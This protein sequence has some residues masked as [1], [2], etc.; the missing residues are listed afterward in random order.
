[1]MLEDLYRLLRSS[2]VQAQG[3][4]DTM[5]QPVVVLDQGFCVATAN[6]AFIRTF[7][8]ERDDILGRCFFDLGNGQWDIEELRQLIALVIPKASAVIGFE[9]THDFP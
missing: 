3:V 5:T 6:N 1:M 9:V 8:V 4:V 2:H 7:K